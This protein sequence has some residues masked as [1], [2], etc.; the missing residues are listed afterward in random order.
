MGWFPCIP[1]PFY[2][3]KDTPWVF[4][5]SDSESSCLLIYS[6]PSLPGLAFSQQRQ[7]TLV[8]DRVSHQLFFV[9]H[10]LTFS[11]AVYER[12]LVSTHDFLLV[13]SHRSVKWWLCVCLFV[14]NVPVGVCVYHNMLSYLT[15]CGAWGMCPELVTLRTEK[16]PVWGLW[17]A[18]RGWRVSLA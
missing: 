14:E 4:H 6:E 12:S 13:D 11:S 3:Y 7:K 8:Q 17:F 16:C 1:C 5:S 15:W 9:T 2:S 10:Q 18:P